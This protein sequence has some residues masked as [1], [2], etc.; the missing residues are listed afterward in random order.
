MLRIADHI[1][2][3]PVCGSSERTFVVAALGDWLD[4][5]HPVPQESYS[6]YRCLGCKAVYLGEL[7]SDEILGLYYDSPAYH[8]RKAGL[9]GNRADR[10]SPIWFAYLRFLRPMPVK[11]P[12]KHLD[13]GCGPGDYLVFSRS[14]GWESTGVEYS[15]ESARAARERGLPVVLMSEV[16]Q[17]PDEHFDLVTLNHSLEHLP[18]PV[19]TLATLVRK[20]RAGGTV[21]IELPNLDCLEFRMFGRY[22]S[23]LSAPLHFQFFSDETMRLLGEKV[24]LDLLRCRNN[25]WMIHYFTYSFLSF[26]RHKTGISFSRY[27]SAVISAMA[28]PLTA[29]PSLL[30]P[31]F[32]VQGIVRRYFLQ[33]PGV[34]LA[35]ADGPAE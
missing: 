2:L 17:L 21:Y 29:I 5:G 30:L 13:F 9:T 20:V 22:Y 18:N 12:G 1:R 11:R 6:Y 16:G 3:C 8:V 24:G 19:E 28:F 7:P 23:M 15:D 32:G 25:P 35:G 31:L 34:S 27:H 33:K 14:Y 26:L 10:L 4:S